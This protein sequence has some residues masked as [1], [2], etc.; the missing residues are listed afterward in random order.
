MASLAELEF[1]HE[2]GDPMRILGR[3]VIDIAIHGLDDSSIAS[4]KIPAR[5]GPEIAAFGPMGRVDQRENTIEEAL[6]YVL[7]GEFWVDV[8]FELERVA[9]GAA[10]A[11]EVLHI[12]HADDAFSDEVLR[13]PM[14]SAL[15]HS[16]NIREP[17][18]SNLS[19]AFCDIPDGSRLILLRTNRVLDIVVVELLE[20][21]SVAAFIEKTTQ[22]LAGL[23]WMLLASAGLTG[24]KYTLHVGR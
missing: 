12:R 1:S 20:D 15:E 24:R 6:G 18:E 8:A 3:I 9:T 11:H 2:L 4:L 5:I 7:S 10:V 21:K 17:L 23:T 13:S 16:D 19:N 14:M 22:K